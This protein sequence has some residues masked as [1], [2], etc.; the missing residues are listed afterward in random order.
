MSKLVDVQD[1]VENAPFACISCGVPLLGYLRQFVPIPSDPAI[2][3]EGAVGLSIFLA[4]FTLVVARALVKRTTL[5]RDAVQGP[6]AIFFLLFMSNVLS[7]DFM[8]SWLLMFPTATA[9]LVCAEKF[10]RQS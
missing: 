7:N 4:C 8:L 1:I 6:V 5:S 2:S 3:H 10:I 9:S